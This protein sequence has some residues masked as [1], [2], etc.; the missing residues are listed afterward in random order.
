MVV[1]NVPDKY[2]LIA[3]VPPEGVDA[4]LQVLLMCKRRVEV[5]DY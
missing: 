4:M 5:A 3:V 1:N 2:D